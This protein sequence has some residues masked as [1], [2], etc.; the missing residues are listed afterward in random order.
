[1]QCN[2]DERGARVRRLWGIANLGIA[3]LAALL[4]SWSGLWWVWIIAAVALVAGVLG[5][6]EAHKKWCVMRAM[7]VKTPM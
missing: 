1:M 5:L 6:F 2:I 4:A 7:G 3:L